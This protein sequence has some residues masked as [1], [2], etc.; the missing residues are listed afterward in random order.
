M[1]NLERSPSDRG[2]LLPEVEQT[3][4]KMALWKSQNVGPARLEFLYRSLDSAAV[5]RHVKRRLIPRRHENS[6]D[7]NTLCRPLAA[8]WHTIA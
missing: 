6:T 8:K 1:A 3:A 4:R 2:V 5:C 7:S